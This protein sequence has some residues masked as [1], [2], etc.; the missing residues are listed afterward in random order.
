MDKIRAV[1][2]LASSI[3]GVAMVG[4]QQRDVVVVVGRA[5]DDE[6]Y[7]DEGEERRWNST[8]STRSRLCKIFSCVKSDLVNAWLQD[9]P[10]KAVVDAQTV[11]KLACLPW[12]DR[13]ATNSAIGVRS[14]QTKGNGFTGVVSSVEL[15][16]LLVIIIR[17]E[18]GIG[19]ELVNGTENVPGWFP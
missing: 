12:F 19:V 14:G 11:I 7:V 13:P 5:L 2:A 16:Q 8:R 18:A 3:S 1:G 6:V 4:K 10:L 9:V 17:Q 15:D